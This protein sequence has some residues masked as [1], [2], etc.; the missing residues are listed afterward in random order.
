MTS[1]VN[2]IEAIPER[3]DETEVQ[4]FDVYFATGCGC[5]RQCHTRFP[6]EAAFKSRLDSLGL[7]HFDACHVNH[8]HLALLGTLN[9]LMKG[10]ETKTRRSKT[11]DRKNARTAFYFRG[12]PVCQRF[13][14]YVNG[15]GIRRLKNIQQQFQAHGLQVR[16]HETAV[17]GKGLDRLDTHQQHHLALVFIQNFAEANGLQ[18]FGRWQASAT[19]FRDL[20]Y[21]P[22]QASFT[23]RAVFEAFGDV[24]RHKNYPTISYSLFSELWQLHFPNILL[25]DD[26]PTAREPCIECRSF[27]Q[28][29]AAARDAS[30]IAATAQHLA[31][32]QEMGNELDHY[33]ASIEQCRE[34]FRV[35]REKYRIGYEQHTRIGNDEAYFLLVNLSTMHY[36]IDWYTTLS[37][38]YLGW[39]G[40]TS[41]L[42]SGYKVALLGIAIEPIEKF[43]IYIVPEYVCH[44]QEHLG[45]ITLSLLDHFHQTYRYNEKETYIHLTNSS[46]SGPRNSLLLSYWMWRTFQGEMDRTMVSYLPGAHAH[47]WNDLLMGA[48]RKKLRSCQLASL[49]ELKTL[50]E[51]CFKEERDYDN[52]IKFEVDVYLVGDDDGQLGVPLHD[53]QQRLA[54]F[55]QLNGETIMAQMRHFEIN[56]GLPGLLLC[57]R[58]LAGEVLSYK[59][60]NV[61]NVPLMG[62]GGGMDSFKL[63]PA[64][65]SPERRRYLQKKIVPLLNERYHGLKLWDFGPLELEEDDDDDQTKQLTKKV[66]R[67]SKTPCCTY[68]RQEGHRENAFGRISCP[69]KKMD[70]Q[71]TETPLRIDEVFELGT[72]QDNE[73]GIDMIVQSPL[74]LDGLDV[75]IEEPGDVIASGSQFLN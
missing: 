15:A 35:E 60:F 57:R 31:H 72:A 62:G 45:N 11:E 38:P 64:P 30:K 73:G 51:R 50:A 12:Q 33:Y 28:N 3:F 2:N 46:T 48:L 32:L 7:D 22:T 4:H 5:T 42:E 44:A 66:K 34:S 74:D 24:C 58:T 41:Y 56:S 49:A 20:Y 75:V 65:M 52:K 63:V 71:L 27:S 43:V 18:L 70:S 36:T 39:R 69:Q 29:I 16:P 40:N 8:Q 59:I 54:M 61:E 1:V 47:S 23:R 67:S 68:C 17:K 10:Q 14:L 6:K 9:A 21:L 19:E 26:E 53:W 13:F 37:L 25:A 55:N